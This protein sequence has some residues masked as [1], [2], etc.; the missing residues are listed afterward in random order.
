VFYVKCFVY[1][2][3]TSLPVK[4]WLV[5]S[6]EFDTYVHSDFLISVFVVDVN[7]C[8]EIIK[9]KIC[10]HFPAHFIT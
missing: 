1:A 8:F 10:R 4:D 2:S 3:I 5:L 9:K 7:F 6:L